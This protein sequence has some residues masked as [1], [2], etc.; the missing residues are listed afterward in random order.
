MTKCT[1][2][3]P[4]LAAVA[5]AGR[6]TT[7]KMPDG[8]TKIRFSDEAANSLASL[9]PTGVVTGI[10]GGA[11]SGGLDLNYSLSPLNSGEYLYLNGQYDFECAA[12]MLYSAKSG[13]PMDAKISKTCRDGYFLRQEQLRM[14]GKPYDR[15]VPA[16]D[17]ANPS[18]AYWEKVAGRTVSQLAP[19]NQFKVRFAGYPR[20]DR[21]GNISIRV[22]FM[23]AADGQ[24]ADLVTTPE[25]TPVV[26][27]DA[28]F[29]QGMR[30]RVAELNTQIGELI[31]CEAVLGYSKAV[32][33]GPR[34]SSISAGD[35]SRY[36]V[37]FTV[38]SMGCKDHSRQFSA[39]PR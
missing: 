1:L 35:Y 34:P 10:A 6:V 26:L 13:Q 17:P 11:G 31:A 16:Y 23:G 39:A 25:R 14:A 28:G 4:I 8:T 27:D 20:V 15:G 18:N 19:I 12:A 32:D 5:M 7:E 24:Y 2:I 22:S 9:M 37:R 33:K 29:A 38:A 3:L 30:K 21:N 36:E